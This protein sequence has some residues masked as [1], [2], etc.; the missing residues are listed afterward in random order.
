MKKTIQFKSAEDLFAGRLRGNQLMLSSLAIGPEAA[1]LLWKS[2]R[3]KEI[4]WLDFDDNRLGDEGVGE[5]A[6]CEFLINL[7]YLNLNKNGVKDGGLKLLSRSKNLGKLK[8][9]HLKHN[10]IQGEGV[11]ALMESGTLDSLQSLQFHEGWTCKRME[12]WKYKS[13]G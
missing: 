2:P 10:P 12:G 5:L 3:M 4:T 7:Q 6:V 13:K 8:R 1:R 9:L 11:L